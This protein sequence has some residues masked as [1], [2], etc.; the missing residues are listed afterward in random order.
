LIDQLI[1]TVFSTLSESREGE[2]N[3]R[4]DTK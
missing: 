4:E 2:V 1:S 3:L